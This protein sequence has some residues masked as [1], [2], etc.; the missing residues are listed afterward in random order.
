MQL[1]SIRTESGSRPAIHLPGQGAVL[2]RDLLGRDPGSD[3]VPLLQPESLTTLAAAAANWDGQHLWP[4]ATYAAPYRTP[5]K[6]LGIGLNYGAHA[7]DLGA[8]IPRTSP[9]SFFKGAHTIVG[10]GEPIV[11]PSGIGKVTAEAELGLVIGRDCYRVSE[12]DALDYVAGVVAILDQT[13]EEVLLEN[14]R[15]LTRVKNYPTFF[16]FGP[17]VIT[18]DEV[19]AAVG[20]LDELSVTTVHNGGDHRTDVVAG[21]TF[22]PA[23]LLS[24]HSHVMPFHPGDILS[25]GTPG[26]VAITGGDTVGCRLGNGLSVLTNPVADDDPAS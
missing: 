19:L 6:I 14:P 24:F 1:C 25:T 11:V 26:A 2:I 3:L 18:M 9:A 10:P 23:E 8:P 13:A 7:G 4:A 12:A 21:M 17:V 20:N 22:S 5:G 16:S 15:Y